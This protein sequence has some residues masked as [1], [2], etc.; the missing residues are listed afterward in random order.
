[1][2]VVRSNMTRGGKARAENGQ[3]M[4]E[5]S[6]TF[7][8]F[9][10][11]I[12]GVINLMLIAYNFNLAQRV[13]WEAARKASIG[14]SN[15]SIANLIYDQFAQNFFA[16]PFLVSA[17]QFDRNT[18]ITP[19]NQ[20]DRV[21]DTT[22]TVN[23]GFRTRFV[24]FSEM[25]SV[26]ASFPVYSTLTVIANNDLDRDGRFDTTTISARADNRLFDHDNDNVN[27]ITTDT[28]DDNDGRADAVDT[29]RLLY[30]GGIYTLDT[31]L[32]FRAVGKLAGGQ[33]FARVIYPLSDGMSRDSGSYPAFP[34]QIPR[35]R[36]LAN[37]T[38]HMIVRVDLS[39]DRNNNGWD[40]KW[41]M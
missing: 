28:D 25:A 41:D 9:I 22:V 24:M 8:I 23:V 32:G 34:Q 40:D 19:N 30:V 36:Y 6:L 4:V 18:F 1:M 2:T 27:D 5:F 37:G 39:Q 29:G 15:A 11:V 20:F 31:G 33:F 26:G 21:H 16:T 10:F 13:A 14:A 12:I 3:Y 7:V 35:D 38:Y 17:I